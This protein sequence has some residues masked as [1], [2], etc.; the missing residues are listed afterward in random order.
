MQDPIMPSFF[1]GTSEPK[2]ERPSFLGEKPKPKKT[3]ARKAMKKIGG[4]V[5]TQFGVKKRRPA[6]KGKLRISKQL[7]GAKFW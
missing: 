2:P 6:Y 1:G 5:K 7:Q 4:F 3:E